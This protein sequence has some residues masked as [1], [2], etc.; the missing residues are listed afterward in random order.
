MADKERVKNMMNA[1]QCNEY[2][3]SGSIHLSQIG[4]NIVEVLKKGKF[5]FAFHVT[6]KSF[7]DKD[8]PLTEEST[9]LN[10]DLR[11][12]FDELCLSFF[13]KEMLELV[14]FFQA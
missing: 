5:L 2:G 9:N 13:A 11:G 10:L 6:D 1:F 4:A 8:Y 3:S 14:S 7:P 12:K